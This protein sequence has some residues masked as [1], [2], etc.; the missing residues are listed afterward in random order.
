MEKKTKKHKD[1]TLP[2][3]VLYATSAGLGGIG[4]NSVAHE[5]V[6]GLYEHNLLRRAVAF[7]N[8]QEEVPRAKI[9]SLH[10][11][12]VRLLSFLES[13]YYYALKKR[14]L[15]RVAARMLRKV[16]ADFF[17]GWSGECLH[18][19]RAAR[20]LGLPTV[21]EVPTWHRNK[22]KRKGRMTGSER[23]L[24]KK[25][26][27]QRWKES[28]LVTRQEVMEEYD[29][30]DLILVLSEFARETFLRAGIPAHKLFLTS[31]GVDASRFTP[32]PRPDKFRAIFV[33]ALIK[34]KGVHV[35]LE[36]WKKLNLPEA[37]LFLVGQVHPEIEP[38]LRE[39]ATSTVKTIGFSRQAEY[40]FGNA[41]AHILP[42]SCE[43]SAKTTYEAA[44]CGLPQIATHES[45]DVVQDGFNGLIVPPED[46]DALA[47]A[48]RR[49]YDSPDLVKRM[50]AAGRE[51]I[52]SNFTWDH[53]RQRVLE[54]YRQVWAQ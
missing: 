17:H 45:G 20:R 11:H 1:R 34:R 10:R 18:S 4:L 35:L 25:P 19:L 46:P 27:A 41:T 9:T 48:I 7:E 6:L 21:I 13:R 39:L 30:A 2:R 53:Y 37:E 43:G 36:A 51:R 47:A 54:A 16:G 40:F 33:G 26:W 23:E 38:Y 14:T 8:A 29:L 32:Q 44:A 12:P 28:L 42:S 24:I 22:G 15:D 49:L 31:R 50:G 52:L 3:R 5:T